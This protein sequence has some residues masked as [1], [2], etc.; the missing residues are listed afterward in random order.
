MVRNTHS[1]KGF[2]TAARNRAHGALPRIDLRVVRF[3]T[4]PTLVDGL[5]PRFGIMY[6]KGHAFFIDAPHG[7]VI[8]N[9]S[10]VHQGSY[11]VFYPEESSWREAEAAL[12]V[13]TNR[14]SPGDS[15]QSFVDADVEGYRSKFGDADVIAGTPIKTSDK[16]Q[17]QVQNF[18]S[19]EAK[20][21]DLV[22]YIEEETIFVVIALNST[23][24]EARERALPAFE[25]LVRS[26]GFWTSDVRIETE[27]RAK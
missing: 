14:R 25:E 4:I 24:R 10:G 1:T 5:A 19:D 9:R 23:S 3:T 27:T 16:K 6:G 15:L 22:A 18:F 13:T 20:N 21:W 2:S 8:D 17:A 26:Y 11:A 7:W 12:A